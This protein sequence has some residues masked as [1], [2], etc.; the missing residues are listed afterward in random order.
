MSK[1]VKYS[2]LMTL[3]LVVTIPSAVGTPIVAVTGECSGPVDGMYTYSYIV[4]NNVSSPEN[5]WDFWLYPTVPFTNVSQITDEFD[6]IL[7]DYFTDWESY[8]R[9]FSTDASYDITPGGCLSG[10]SYDSASGPGI[11]CYDQGGCDPPTG[12]PTGNY[13]SGNTVGPVPEPTTILLIGAALAG[14]LGVGRHRRR[15]TP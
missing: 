15:R 9:W 8:I 14:L 2:I 5:V 7:W 12:S 10:F 13:T 4:H 11:T 6:W 1:A 3:M